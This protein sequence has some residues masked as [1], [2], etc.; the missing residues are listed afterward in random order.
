MPS[1]T[2][3]LI[4]VSGLVTGRVAFAVLL[5]VLFGVG[6]M[7][8]ISA[9]G[10][11]TLKGMDLVRS[12]SGKARWLAGAARVLPRVAAWAVIVLGVTY[13]GLGVAALVA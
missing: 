11:L 8:T 10:W 7:V 13:L 5:V 2:V 9:V 12:G 6:M 3:F 4:L 1:P